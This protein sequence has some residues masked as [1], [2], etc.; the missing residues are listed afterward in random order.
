MKLITKVIATLDLKSILGMSGGTI[1]RHI[2]L[3][4][5]E[6]NKELQ[7]ILQAVRD[8]RDLF[9]NDADMTM[10]LI[11]V[12][13]E[14]EEDYKQAWATAAEKQLLNV[15]GI[16][17][18]SFENQKLADGS[19]RTLTFEPYGTPS[20]LAEEITNWTTPVPKQ[21]EHP[22]A[23]LIPDEVIPKATP[24]PEA[25]APEPGP[26]PEEEFEDDE[27]PVPGGQPPIL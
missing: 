19:P 21:Q 23:P 15:Y 4:V 11:K 2:T 14:R 10:R 20:V 17:K 3:F 18:E 13:P 1:N 12:R 25:E 16:I 8:A 6:D 22:G 27:V 9:K 5:G 24:V 26:Q 7:K